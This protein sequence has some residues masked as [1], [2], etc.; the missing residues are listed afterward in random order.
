VARPLLGPLPGPFIDLQ[1]RCNQI[2]ADRW[3]TFT[4]HRARTTALALHAEGDTLAVLGAGNCNDLDL[5]ALTARF[6]SVH[7]VDLDAEALERAWRRQPGSVARK[8]VLHAPLDLS[9]VLPRLPEF[10]RQPP[11]DA[12]VAALPAAALAAVLAALPGRY[13][14]VLSGC[15]LS[16][17]LHGCAV[18]LGA[19]HP[20]LT[21]ISCALVLAHV[22]LLVLLLAPAG[23]AVLV[24][25][26]ASSERFA[27]DELWGQAEPE[28]LAFELERLH[29]AASGTGPAF[30]RRLFAGDDVLAPLLRASPRLQ[31]PWLWQF[32]ETLSYLVTAWVLQRA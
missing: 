5:P 24:T 29:L 16:Q 1:R 19:D 31:P 23:T 9:G 12:E 10:R 26:M 22:R 21:A 30:L 13:D 32:G 7:L 28:A 18:A 17:I 15:L 20:R 8:L 4:E 3:A 27:L 2:S 25:D 11:T 14:V 6:A